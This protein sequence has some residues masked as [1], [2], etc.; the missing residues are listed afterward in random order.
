MAYVEKEIN[1]KRAFVEYKVTQPTTNFA[2]PFAFV[3]AEQNLRVRLNGIDI[4]DLGYSFLVT[5]N[6]TVQ[7]TPA[8]PHGTLRISRE[9][10]IDENLYKFTAGALFEARTMDKNFEQIRHSQQEVRD[11]FNSL[12][13]ST[14]I[15]LDSFS[16]RVDNLN[17]AFLATQD[18][19]SD[20]VTV[21][22]DTVNT[23]NTALSTANAIDAKASTALS[24]SSTALSTAQGIDAKATD[25]LDNSLHAVLDAASALSTA[26]AIDAKATQA[27]T[28]SATALSSATTALITANAIDNKATQALTNSTGAIKSS[29]NLSDVASATLARANLGVMSSSEVATAIANATPTP[30]DATTT[31]K[32][33]AKIATTAIAQA[34]TNDT[35]FITAKKLRDAL[36][37]SGVLPVY[38]L[39]SWGIIQGTTTPASLSKGVN[40]A[41]IVDEGVGQY[42]V[43]FTTAMPDVN[44]VVLIGSISYSVN[45]Y[46]VYG[47]VKMGSKTVNGFTIVCGFFNTIDISEIYFGVTY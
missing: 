20:L 13:A 1:L 27:L 38:G 31:V 11:N 29:N 23:A 19:V 39:R 34:G 25:A 46:N 9:T 21:S 33:V 42:K 43:I 15:R 14:S 35:D 2:I 3:E 16:D 17:T 6:L 22:A 5:N 32:G 41:S 26:D 7:V 10:D 24:N 8:I 12:E 18:V 45:D 37:A 4:E 40:V 44:Y 36:N 28:D 30:P 47:A